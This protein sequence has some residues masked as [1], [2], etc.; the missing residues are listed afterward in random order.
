MKE[1]VSKVN[2]GDLT[3]LEAMLTSQTTSLAT[4]K[5]PPVVF[6]KQANI[7]NGNQQINNGC[8]LTGTHARRKK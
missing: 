1:K 7:S 2:A 4:M 6:A 8:Y 3:G 5:N